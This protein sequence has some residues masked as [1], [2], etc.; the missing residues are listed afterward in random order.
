MS[1][2]NGPLILDEDSGED[3]LLSVTATLL[4]S[5]SEG[6]E[7]LN[8]E[9]KGLVSIFPP[10]G[11]LN[12]QL[13]GPAHPQDF[14]ATLSTL[15][16]ENLNDNHQNLHR[17]IEVVATDD[18]QLTS[19][20]S[21][22]SITILP[23]NDPPSLRL[24]STTNY[25]VVYT[26][27]SGPVQLTSAGF[28][29]SDV[30]SL[31]LEQAEIEILNPVDT[32][33]EFLI[34][35]STLLTTAL[36]TSTI[37]IVTGPAAVE[38]FASHL[39]SVRYLN[40]ATSPT[41][42][43]RVVRFLV[44]DGSL[45]DEAFTEVTVVPVNDP[46]VL[47]L[48]G[49]GQGVDSRV[50]FLEEGPPVS[51]TQ[52]SSL[53]IYDSDSS[54]IHS[55]TIQIVPP[56]NMRSEILTAN[57]STTV[58]ISSVFDTADATL[59]LSGI[60]S[61]EEY[62]STLLS[63]RY[64]NQADEPLGTQRT[65]QLHV[66][67]GELN[68]NTALVT[69]VFV[70]I[71]DAPVIT[72]DGASATYSTVFLENGPSVPLV[73]TR[74]AAITDVD[75]T[76]LAFLTITVYN[77]LNGNQEFLLFDNVS[78]LVFD[79]RI[80]PQK[81]TYN[82]TFAPS[83]AS[84][85]TYS[86]FLLSLSYINQ[87]KEPNATLSR[88][89]AVQTSD[90]SL[91]SNTAIS[92]IS[93]ILIDDNQPQFS[94]ELYHFQ[95]SEDS[96]PGVT[97]GS[98][99]ASDQD[100]GD[101]FFYAISTSSSSEV[102][103]FEINQSTGTL[104]LS[105]S[106]DREDTSSYNLT[107]LLTR[108]V[109]PFSVFDSTASVTITVLDVND[110]EPTFNQSAYE[111]VVSEN[112]SV[113][114]TVGH[115]V[116]DDRDIGLNGEVE[117]SLS[118]NVDD[119]TVNA[120]TGEIII[121]NLLDREI[122]SFFSFLVTARD[123]GT[124]SLSSQ[125]SVSVRVTDV[126]DN[127]P[128]FSQ[129]S[130]S[131]QL[132]ETTPVGTTILEIAASDEDSG[133]NAL[134]VFSL[135][136]SNSPFIL[137]PSTGVL[138]VGDTLSP[139]THQ[140]TLTA[141]DSGRP[142][143]STTAQLTVQVVSFN[144]T[145]PFF[146]QP[147]YEGTIVENSPPGLSILTVL[148]LDPVSSNP[149]IYSI[150]TVSDDFVIDANT[151]TVSSNTNFDRET[152]ALYQ[153]Q[154]TATAAADA[155]RQ[156]FA[157]VVIQVT[158][159]NDFPPM[160]T[161]TDYSFT[162]V[163]NLSP[164]ETVGAVLARD[165]SD[166]GDNAQITS[167]DISDPKFTVSTLGIIMLVG[168]LDR[169]L[170]NMYVMTI[171]AVDGGIPAL[172]GI[173]Q[174]TLEVLDENDNAP[175]FTSLTYSVNVTE[176][177]GVARFLLQVSAN[178]PDVGTNADIIYSTNS[179]SLVSIDSLSGVIVTATTYDFEENPVIN[180]TLFA[181][182]SGS[183]P[184]TAT[185]MLVINV[186]DIDDSPPIFSSRQYVA[187][188][189]EGQ[190]VNSHVVSLSAS[191]SDSSPENV[192]RFEILSGDT[193]AMFIVDAN[194]TLL[195]SAELD[196]ETVSQYSL[197]VEASNLNV[198]GDRI[199]SR[200]SVSVS[201][202]DVNDNP[203]QFLELPYLFS[204][205]ENSPGGQ[206]VGTV[207]VT[208]IDQGVNANITLFRI[209]SGDPGGDFSMDPLRGTLH[210]AEEGVIDRETLDTY[211]LV[212]EV[213]DGGT[214]QLSS[215]AIVTIE[216]TDIN[217][218]SP[219]FEEDMYTVVIAEDTPL[220][221][222]LLTVS[223]SD[224]D[225]GSNADV[226]YTINDIT[227]PV[228][229]NATSGDVILITPLDFES[230]S[231][232]DVIVIAVDGGIP[233]LSSST[234][235]SVVI[236]D[237]DDLPVVF[238]P[239][240]Y[241]V[242]VFENVPVGTTIATV[243]A[244]DLDTQPNTP[245]VYSLTV[246][247]AP[248]SIDTQSG[249][250][251][252][253]LPLDRESVASYVIT[254]LASNTPVVTASATVVIQIMD[255]HD[256][257]PSFPDGPFQFQ[258][259]ESAPV[260]M[261]LGQIV[262]V[263]GDLDLAGAIVEYTLINA[264]EFHI[265][266]STGV[267]SVA[268]ILDFETTSTYEIVVTARD[269]G[270][271]SLIGSSMVVIQVTDVNDNAPVFT[272]PLTT[273]VPE[274]EPVG[275]VIATVTATDVDSDDADIRFS[276]SSPIVPFS[277]DPLSGE[278]NI[279]APL[280]LGTYAVPIIATDSGG[281]PQLS[282]AT[283]TVMVTDSNEHPSFSQSSYSVELSEATSIGEQVVQVRATDSDVGPN[284]NL[285][286]S[287]QPSD[288][289]IIHPITGVITLSSTLDYEL[290]ESYTLVL[291]V[292]DSGSPPL[293]AR[294]ELIVRVLD[295]NDNPPLFS[296]D[297]YSV[298][299]AEDIPPNTVIIT[300][301]ASDLDSGNNG[302]I[303]YSI[304]QAS[305]DS[306][307]TIDP[308]SGEI[309][310]LR[311]L[312]F[313]TLDNF[314]LVI[315]VRDG[316]Q[317][318]MFSMVS[319]Y[320]TVDDVDD[321]PPIFSRNAYNV[322]VDEDVSIGLV[323][324]TLT[325]TDADSG[326][327]AHII[328][329]IINVTTAPFHVDSESGNVSIGFPGLDYEN[330]T[331]YHLTV[332][333]FN[334]FSS[335]FTATVTLII[336]VDDVN[337]NAPQFEPNSLIITVPESSP[338]GTVLGQV[339]AT[340]SD[341]GTNS[342]LEYG[343]E[344]NTLLAVDSDTGD[345][346]LQ[347]VLDFET[348]SVV[349]I[350]V[351]VHDA[352][353]PR[354]VMNSTLVLNILD[355]NDNAPVLSIDPSGF[356]FT[357]GSDSI[358]IGMGIAV[359]DSDTLP[360]QS[361]SISLYL[362]SI[363]SETSSSDFIT[364][365]RAFSES[366]GL[367]VN[368]T[369]H[370]IRLQ[371]SQ[372]AGIYVSV[373]RLLRFGNT[374]E[375]P[376]ATGRLIEISVR[377]S[378]FT[379]NSAIIAVTV[380]LVN[381]N[382]PVLDL[383][384][385][386]VDGLDYQ[387]VFIE[388]GFFV[389]AVSSDAT[390]TDPDG[391]DFEYIRAII[392]NPLDGSHEQISAFSTSRDV[393]VFQN[394]SGLYLLGPA[395]ASSFESTLRSITYQNAAD[396]P[397]EPQTER[398]IRFEVSDGQFLSSPVTT[399]VIIQPVNDPPSISLGSST[400]D[401]I[402]TYVESVGYVEVFSAM[403]SLRDDDSTKLSFVN[404]T[405]RDYQSSVDRFNFTIAN[406]G[407]IT[408]QFLS[409]TLLV[410]G[411]ANIDEF[412]DVLRSVRY[413]NSRVEMD[414]FDQLGVSRIIEITASDGGSATS[415]IA[416]AFVTFQAVNDP[417]LV[418]LNGPDN[419][420]QDIDI[421][422]VEGDERVRVASEQATVV[423]VDSDTLSFVA[424]QLFGVADNESETLII[425]E[426]ITNIVSSYNSFTNTLTLSGPA[427]VAEF[428]SVLR[429]LHYVNI[430]SEP[431]PG[432]R[433]IEIV[434]SDAMATSMAAIA[435][436]SIAAIN[437][438]PT[439]S[440]MGSGRP[441]MEGGD[442]VS[443]FLE[444]TV[445]LR[446]SDNSVLSS[447]E[448][449]IE[450]ALDGP[451]EVISSSMTEDIHVMRTQLSPSLT[452]IFTF[453]ATSEGT[454]EDFT[455]LVE[456]L[457]YLNSAAEPSPQPR[458]ISFR[459]S[460]SVDYSDAINITVDIILI[461]DNHPMFTNDNITLSIPE[462]ASIGEIIASLE[463]VD[464]DQDS[465]LEYSLLESFNALFT[466]TPSSGVVM[467]NGALDRETSDRYSL[468]IVVS[469]ELNTASI[470]VTI[471]ITDVND[472]VP[473]FSE[474][475]V[476]VSISES[477]NIG[478]PVLLI[479]ATDDDLGENGRL[480]FSISNNNEESA[481][482]IDQ[483]SGLL[484]TSVILD[485]E[486]VETYSLLVMVSDRGIPPLSSSTTV[487]VAVTDVNDNSP[488]FIPDS[489]SV[490]WS[491][492]IGIG[493]ELYT[494]RAVDPDSS[495]HLLYTILSGNNGTLFSVDPIFG[496]IILEI[497][498][499]RENDDKHVLIIEA[500]D[501]VFAA[502]LELIIIVLDVDD[503]PPTFTRNFQSISL[504][505]NSTVGTVLL[506][507]NASD[508]DT[509]LNAAFEYRI[510]SGD[511]TSRFTINTNT[512]E[513][514]LAGAVDRE[515]EDSYEL[516]I[517]VRSLS[518][519][520]LNDTAIVR[521]LLVDIND[522]P[523]IFEM[524]FYEFAALENVTNGTVIGWV[525]ASDEDLGRNGEVSFSL[526]PISTIFAINTEGDIIVTSGLDHEE[527]DEYMLSVVAQDN[528]YPSL[529]ATA[530]VVVSVGDIN[531]NTPLFMGDMLS[532]TIQ[533]N[534][535]VGSEITTVTATDADSGENGEIMY[536]I[537][538]SDN[539]NL[540]A[541]NRDNGM[542]VTAVELDFERHPS[543]LHITVTAYDSGPQS[544]SSSIE[545]E[546]ILLEINEF[547]PM[548][549][550]TEY[551]VQ[552]S[553]DLPPSTVILTVNAT[554][555]DIGNS[556][557]IEYGLSGMT[558]SME[559]FIINST[560]GDITTL[561][562]LDR[563]M[564]SFHEII[565][566]ATNTHTNPMLSSQ[567]VVVV[568]L[569]DVNDN[570]PVFDQSEYSIAVVMSTAVGTTLLSVG[571]TDADS[572]TNS[573]ILYTGTDTSGYFQVSPST[574]DIILK[575]SFN[576][577]STITFTVT[578]S[579]LGTPT[580]SASVTVI[581]RVIQPLGV[582][583]S[584]HG[585]GFLLEETASV[586]QSFGLFANVPPG[587]EGMLTASLG[588][589][590]IT[591]AYVTAHP[592][593]VGVRGVVLDERVWHDRPEVG[594]VVQVYGE[595]G[596]VHCQPTEV[597]VTINPDPAIGS[598]QT[599]QVTCTSS[600]SDGFCEAFVVLPEA[601]FDHDL[602]EA[603][604]SVTIRLLDSDDLPVII[605]TV[606]I[607]AEPNDEV[608][609]GIVL[610][611]PSRPQSPGELFTAV[612]AAHAGYPV[613]TFSLRCA[614]SAQLSIEE[615]VVDSVKWT[616][617]SRWFE[618]S[619]VGIAAF[620]ADPVSSESIED[621]ITDWEELFSLRVRVKQDVSSSGII[622][623]TL[624]Y[625]SNILNDKL[626]PRGLV[627]PAPV[628]P[629]SANN[630]RDSPH[631]VILVASSVP[632]ALLSYASQA[633]IVNTAVFNGD[634][635]Q[636]GLT[637]Y[638]VY[639]NGLASISG[640]MVSCDSTSSAFQLSTDCSSVLLT[641]NETSGADMDEIHVSFGNFTKTISLRV[642]YPSTTPSIIATPSTAQAVS[643]W[644]ATDTSG[645]CTQ[646]YLPI[647]LTVHAIYSYHPTLGPSFTVNVL[648]L[649]QDVLSSSDPTV[650]TVLNS[651]TVRA[652]S[653]G[654]SVISAGESI[655]PATVTVTNELLQ[656]SIIETT[657][658]T[659]LQLSLPLPRSYGIVS[660]QLA[661]T[662]IEQ[663][664]SSINT[665][666]YSSVSA[667]ASDGS[668]FILT[669]E[670]GLQFYSL[671]HSIVQISDNNSIS[672]VDS[673][674]GDFL[675]V[676]WVSP[677][678]GELIASDVVSLEVDIPDPVD[679]LI[680]LSSSRI[681]RPG[682][683]AE[684]SGLPTSS[685]LSIT[686]IYT[687]GLTQDVT[688]HPDTSIKFIY[689]QDLVNI[690]VLTAPSLEHIISTMTSVEFGMVL[691]T[692]SYKSLPAA[693]VN[694]SLG[695]VGFERLSLH[696]LPYPTYPG[697]E[698]NTKSV[699]YQ[700]EDTGVFQ[701]ASLE[702]E[703]V[704]SDNSTFSVTESPLTIF[705]ITNSSP[706]VS[707][708]DNIVLSSG[709][710]MVHIEGRFGT[711]SAATTLTFSAQPVTITSLFNFTLIETT[712]SD[713]LS[714]EIGY[715]SSLS[716]DAVFNDSTVFTSF[717][718][719]ADG[720]FQSLISITSDTPT[721]ARVSSPRGA[722]TLT[723]N[724][725]S[726]ITLTAAYVTSGESV[727]LN[728]FCNLQP[729]VGDVDVGFVSGPPIPPVKIDE[730]FTVPVT[731]NAGTQQMESF[732]LIMLY[733][734]GRLSIV[735]FANGDDWQLGNL[736]VDDM[737]SQGLIHVQGSIDN[738]ELAPSGLVHVA[739]LIFMADGVGTT[740]LDGLV[741]SLVDIDGV[742]IPTNG[743]ANRGFVAGK[744]S[745]VVSAELGR[746]RRAIRPEEVRLRFRRNALCLTT[747]P[748]VV[749]ENHRERGD[750]N[751][752]C[753]F[754][755][756]DPTYLLAYHT[757]HLFDFQLSS[758]S[759]LLLSL[760]PAQLEALDVDGNTV[761][762]VSDAY[763]LSQ[764]ETGHLKFLTDI[765]IT[766]VQND[767]KCFFA[768]N[769][770]LAGKGDS[771]ATDDTTV[772][773][774]DISLPFDPSFENQRLFEES[775]FA[776][777]SLSE[778]SKGVSLQGGILEAEYLAPGTFGVQFQ[779]NVTSDDIGLGVIQI[780]SSSG[781]M[782]SL[783]RTRALLGHP[784]PP[785]SYPHA[786]NLN[787]PAFSDSTTIS[788]L[789]GYNPLTTF[790]NTLSSGVC[791]TPPGPPIVSPLSY[792]VAITENLPR[793]TTVVEIN[794]TSQSNEPLSFSIITGNVDDVF[795]IDSFGVVIVSGELD[796]EE[797][798]EFELE[799]AVTDPATSRYTTATVFITV[800][801][802]NDNAPQFTAIP[803]ILLPQNTPPG[804]VIAT[805]TASDADSGTSADITF[806]I[807]SDDNTF[808]IEETLGVI[809]LMKSLDFDTQSYYEVIITAFDGG[810]PQLNSTLSLNVTVLPPDPTV[811]EFSTPLLNHS[812]A[813][814][815]PPGHVIIQ[816]NAVP[817]SNETLNVTINYSLNAPLNGLFTID[818]MTGEVSVSGSLDR[819]TQDFY[820]LQVSASITNI[821]RSVP[822]FA[823]VSITVLDINDNPP[824]FVQSNYST[825]LTE[826]SP[827]GSLH[828]A[829]TA[830]D[831]D[832]RENGTIVFTL[833]ED[834]PLLYLSNGILSNAMAI[835]FENH[836]VLDVSVIASDQG[837]PPLSTAINVTIMIED[838]NDNPPTITAS[839]DD[840]VT[841]SEGLLLGTT[842]FTVS[843]NDR[844]S[845]AVNG[846]VTLSLVN[847][848]TQFIF[849]TTTGDIA[850]VQSLDYESEQNLTILVWVTDSGPPVMSS[851]AELVV[852]IEDENDNSPIFSENEYSIVVSEFESV[853]SV[854][855]SLTITD[856]D[857]EPYTA[858]E[859]TFEPGSALTPFNLTSDG[860][861]I[862]SEPLDHEMN[863]AY[864]LLVRAMNTAPGAN[865]T[866]TNISVEVTDENEFFP[867]FDMDLYNA[868]VSEE[869]AGEFVITI[870]ATDMDS[871]ANISYMIRGVESAI[872]DISQN[873][874]ILTSVPLDRENV[875]NYQVIVVASD[876]SQSEKISTAIIMVTVSDI[877]DNAPTILPFDD[878]SIS[879]SLVPG[880][881]VAT[882]R[883]ED[884]DEGENGA[885]Q[886]SLREDATDFNISVT[887]DLLVAAALNALDTPQHILTLVA[888][889]QGSPSLSSSALVTITILTFP[890]PYFAE[891]IYTANITENNSK[892]VS[893]LQV[894][895]TSRD[896]N[897][898]ITYS[899]LPSNDAIIA[900][901]FS[902]DSNT[903]VVKILESLD[904]EET[905]F[906]NFT[907]VASVFDNGSELTDTAHI[908]VYVEDMNDN[909]PMFDDSDFTVRVNETTLNGSLVATFHASDNDLDQNA[910]IYYSLTSLNSSES[911][912]FDIDRT[913]GR[914]TTVGS[915]V[916]KTGNYP[917]LLQA[918]NPD[919]VGSLS[920]TAAVTVIVDHINEFPPVFGESPY[921][922][923]IREDTVTGINP[924]LTVS[925]T[926][927]DQGTAGQVDYS[928]IDNPALSLFSLNSTTGDITLSSSLDYETASMFSLLVSAIDSGVPSR[929]AVSEILVM[930]LDVNDN[931]PVFSQP[932]YSGVIE[933]NVAR[934]QS[935]LQLVVSDNDTEINSQ[936]NYVIITPLVDM[937]FSVY[938]NGMV[939][940]EVEFDADNTTFSDS[941]TFDVVAVNDGAGGRLSAAAT[942]MVYV[943]DLNDNS[944]LFSELV[945]SRVIKS[946]QEAGI[947]VITV[948]ARDE[949]RNEENNQIQFSLTN[950]VPNGILEI[951]PL[952]GIVSLAQSVEE[953]VNISAVVV[954]RDSGNPPN[955]VTTE[956]HVTVLAPD[957]LTA[958]REYDITLSSGPGLSLTGF[959]TET[960]ENT[961]QQHISFALGR[962]DSDSHTF[963]A[964]LGREMGSIQIPLERLAP[965]SV[966]AVLMTPD[967]WHDDRRIQVALQVR[968][969]FG[970]VQ[971]DATAHPMVQVTHPSITPP[972]GTTC[973]PSLR[974]GICIVTID[975][976]D[977]WFIFDAT[978]LTVSYGLTV[979]AVL[980]VLGTVQLYPIPHFNVESSIYVYLEMP[981]R[982]LIRGEEITVPVYGEAGQSSVTSY[983][984]SID[985]S[986]EVE[987]NELIV[988]QSDWQ[989]ETIPTVTGGMTIT[990]VRA[991]QTILH[992]SGRTHLFDISATISPN[993]TVLDTLVDNTITISILF[994]GDSD[995]SQLLPEPSQPSVPALALT[996][997]GIEAVG[998]L[999][1000]DSDKPLGL[1001]A[1002][1003]AQAE[1004]VNT[1005]LL[1006][1007]NTVSVPLTT[1008]SIQRHAPI[1009][1010][1011][1012]PDS[1013][1014]SEDENV[1015][1016]TDC[1017]M[1018]YISS[1019]QTQGSESAIVTVSFSDLRTSFPVRVWV[1020][1021]F[1022][1023]KLTS[1024]DTVLN[1025]VEGWF[1026]SSM[1027]CRPNYQRTTIRAFSN[1028]TNSNSS[1029]W[1030]IDVTDVVIASLHSTNS[1031]IIEVN[1032]DIITGISPGV[1033]TIQ[1034]QL[1035][1036]KT[1037]EL[1038]FNVTDIPS[1039]VLGLDVRVITDLRLLATP[1040]EGNRLTGT[1041]LN[1042]I[1043][1044]QNFASEGA[1045]GSVITA[1046]VFDDGSRMILNGSYDGISLLSLNTSVLRLL[1047]DGETV[1048]ALGS[1049]S[1050]DL[1051]QAEWR[1052]N[1053][1054]CS[1055]ELI[1056]SGVEEL[1057]IEISPVEGSGAVQHAHSRRR[1058]HTSMQPASELNRPHWKSELSQPLVNDDISSMEVRDLTKSYQ[1059]LPVEKV[1060]RA[1061][1062]SH[1063]RRQIESVIGD[1064]DGNGIFNE[1065]DASFLQRYILTLTPGALVSEET[1066]QQGQYLDIDLSGGDPN[1067]NDVIFL[1068]KMTAGL[1069]QF[1070]TDLN[1071]SPVTDGNCDF[1072]I[1073]V[1074]LTDR[1075]N[1076]P[1077]MPDSASVFFHFVHDNPTFQAMFDSTN[1078]TA[1079]GRVPLVMAD[1080][1081]H[1082]G[1083]VRAEYTSEGVFGMTSSSAINIT[1084]IGVSLIL[1085]TYDN[1086]SETSAL[1087]TVGLFQSAPPVFHSLNLDFISGGNQVSIRR[1088]NGYA[1089]LRYVDNTL[1090]TSECR[1091]RQ[1092]SLFFKQSFYVG[1093]VSENAS[1094]IDI[1095][1096][1097]V[1098]AVTH[1099]PG[1100]IVTYSISDP[1101]RF[1102]F[1103]VNPQTGEIFVVGP[1104]DFDE[1105][1106][1107]DY[1108]FIVF[1109][1110]EIT[1111]AST[1112]MHAN[1113]TV[1114]VDVININD[1115]APVIN[1116]IP[1117]FNL[1118]A[1119]RTVGD[1120]IFTVSASDPDK[1121]TNQLIYGLIPESS[1122]DFM[1123][1124]S[1125]SGAVT[1126]TRS[1127][1128]DIANSIALLNISVSDGLLT[1129]HIQVEITI[1130]LPSF[1131]SQ[1132][1133]TVVIPEDTRIG[1134]TVLHVVIN[1135][1136]MD[1137]QFSFS[1138]SNTSLFSIL[1139]GLNNTSATI[1140]VNG[1141]LDYEEMTVH[1142]I[1143]ILADSS[1144]FHLEAGVIIT[1145]TDVNDNCPMFP[1146]TQYTISLTSQT[1147]RGTVITD[1148]PRAE[1149]ADSEENAVVVYDITSQPRPEYF[1150]IN[1151][1152]SGELTL[1153][1154]SLITGPSSLLIN[1155]T[1156]FDNCTSQVNGS[1157]S[1158]LFEITL[1159]LPL[1160]DSTRLNV[1161]FPSP[1162]QAVLEWNLL[1163]MGTG[1164]D[1165]RTLTRV[1166]IM[1167][1168][1169][1170]S[1171]MG[1172]AS[1173]DSGCNETVES[1174]TTGFTNHTT[1175]TQPFH[1176]YTFQVL[1177][1178]TTQSLRSIVRSPEDGMCIYIMP[1179]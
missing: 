700:F 400:R 662:G 718:P 750:I 181:T 1009:S 395:E 369:P 278:I 888:N 262:A 311:G 316:G 661:T 438:P 657:V 586:S 385:S 1150:S 626:Q 425:N 660:S 679:I 764:V 190:P 825:T 749:C 1096:L 472:N 1136:A 233:Q 1076:N 505:E 314:E 34:A 674:T 58:S 986:P 722:V 847:S 1172:V 554:D 435:T 468:F 408:G 1101:N 902:I 201:V 499:D 527:E 658:F 912:L 675:Q 228:T 1031:S 266:A 268:E 697:S 992:A 595:V 111:F 343:I 29:L 396:E 914:L 682:D 787:L 1170:I 1058:R 125:A 286:F 650:V 188:V 249:D 113:G 280:M 189:R 173:S 1115:L 678:T 1114:H 1138:I 91:A 478:T 325:A 1152:S 23:T 933:E 183:V 1129:S 430:A 2:T 1012:T 358:P 1159:I 793:G 1165:F 1015:V 269:G 1069:Y 924:L 667:V 381:D 731:V 557:I 734:S 1075:T 597:A 932:Q 303:T 797:I 295:D 599:P 1168:C 123:R 298:S 975:L 220:N 995:L 629:I 883:A 372:S 317:P 950:I 397:S 143:L 271:P 864:N 921:N 227:L 258:V 366:Q 1169:G 270:A 842:L 905:G 528:G 200:T 1062:K 917:F 275:V 1160:I 729:T 194:G 242:S 337:D 1061:I 28:Q 868:S 800:S 1108:E 957:D 1131:S 193:N 403:S 521:I 994:L 911:E 850:L 571:A 875:S 880:T 715:E 305:T 352:G 615:L 739:N 664:F 1049:G 461:N 1026:D 512:G 744:I 805:I 27:G 705:L 841:V 340:D 927:D 330:V 970:N 76:N 356:T 36:S 1104:L 1151:S 656:I 836:E 39:Q 500:S 600:I 1072:S 116:A 151:G 816:L 141:T 536:R 937:L 724:H 1102:P 947:T 371:G 244:R 453:L 558:R 86:D 692:V 204:V 762:D 1132:N 284:A 1064:I 273:S 222:V 145:L 1073:N 152:Q 94:P 1167:E 16:Y 497:S 165:S 1014:S 447:V 326:V 913:N 802:I 320:I 205:E 161:Q 312:D 896:P 551:A 1090:T 738:A 506:Q 339:I 926:D 136:P 1068:L 363:G 291:T 898:S 1112:V 735:E 753:I 690:S 422:F 9:G 40:N 449:V 315:Q 530:S 854:L 1080:G 555:M 1035:G 11:G 15:R 539:A 688:T 19:E 85:A 982:P 179:P 33:T 1042:I 684:L 934:G 73:N 997:R 12:L 822:A 195:T 38:L 519:P 164:G 918:S 202:L 154:V 473:I 483:D 221:S 755:D 197:I 652:L 872:F 1043:T 424:A 259:L 1110:E 1121:L 20:P 949:D 649:I 707:I 1083:L 104:S 546:I 133:S 922:L 680:T 144:S 493:S 732:Q 811:L 336:S 342:V 962:Q 860:R 1010:G 459:I 177:V 1089:P 616:Y 1179:N 833:L 878:L 139:L 621:A 540:F 360:L 218:N 574:G 79:R 852:Y 1030:N 454:I 1044:E 368:A 1105:L 671:D 187:T 952:T 641:G 766:P 573:E 457:S 402:L 899:L 1118:P 1176:E 673:G 794:A 935:I 1027:E 543:T 250:I 1002:Y 6:G 362:G 1164:L 267:V 169:E 82:F 1100:S 1143:T 837:S 219:M 771:L 587:S 471:H 993:I 347:D 1005:A 838:M 1120:I 421:Q 494:A 434:A 698:Q 501:G 1006:T 1173:Q 1177:G 274:N 612:A 65:L 677:C 727:E 383:S 1082:G 485:R 119:F 583:F 1137:E 522:S 301:S 559:L 492:D 703:A 156:S 41:F 974:D 791:L 10:S 882:F 632:R 961:Y 929:S 299:L 51:I 549:E 382:I 643:G 174:V 398:F 1154:R 845:D 544:L 848:S 752:D 1000:I 1175:A 302:A 423:D 807:E 1028:F 928:L 620:L 414:Q 570:S 1065:D 686:V 751:G 44:H 813:E 743:V 359:S 48:N 628:R 353:N 309:A 663:E 300:V 1048:V 1127:L 148:A 834:L 1077:A 247:E 24:S 490:E 306:F 518:N 778:S 265:N 78:G 114:V 1041:T 874:S 1103:A 971:T 52:G 644:I 456:S 584:Q 861:L 920:T 607:K 507:H 786:L 297:N 720:V 737:P 824:E 310:T 217:D 897:V 50:Q 1039:E 110:N 146:S 140:L 410:T 331:E 1166:Y 585:A 159:A 13:A 526:L 357:E 723:G 856:A 213:I 653:A 1145:I 335:Q 101:T 862:L 598:S 288:I 14:E 1135:G 318:F 1059:L 666:V 508:R 319:V 63:V 248:F 495:S 503:N 95:L 186:R 768:I 384:G 907:V 243:T 930:V 61:I 1063:F 444:N 88:L 627:T 569:L 390:L 733:N 538:S 1147:P 1078:I 592:R 256:V 153:L 427:E 1066:P 630:E 728:L 740:S 105:Q 717:I 67:D 229:V 938:E 184:L 1050:A 304:V 345:I 989:V 1037:S 364:L 960:S 863:S 308:T 877:N 1053:A 238:E 1125:T 561:S 75:S 377:D 109:S 57:I 789:N 545:I 736:E 748:C 1045:Q 1070:I 234:S 1146:E 556:G 241:S 31:N 90:G 386:S 182:D 721:A 349:E 53:T 460:D 889:D 683:R 582:E 719:Q 562:T 843:V 212:I 236:T 446:D 191:D 445:S 795:S 70:F 216:V 405:V 211:E 955:E 42:G 946:P 292:M 760:I 393:M 809:M 409:G 1033:A 203:P 155:T 712:N 963:T 134:L 1088:Q 251:S 1178:P 969:N 464:N 239:D 130:Y 978:N 246:T 215:T 1134:V 121:E 919:S 329:D 560:S 916:D 645:Q 150:D 49:D 823:V 810:E 171:T 747:P 18:G 491:E 407:N 1018:L 840:N 1144:N 1087:R 22:I 890:A 942:V 633:Q 533:E 1007:G 1139:T 324:L 232:Y 1057:E 1156:A 120:L 953:A 89:A 481:F 693:T 279:T 378:D 361:A 790:S 313:E 1029:V 128:Q 450:N 198:F 510:V 891:D 56:L 1047:E 567:A 541:I 638:V 185:A 640:H 1001:F 441:Y 475:E 711:T 976:P 418:D 208:D 391:D 547:P 990:A 991:D 45:A 225:L 966:D 694:V 572:G 972:L 254:A 129:S 245:I 1171:Q 1109:A 613:A 708:S 66:N 985:T 412:R 885:I 223:A 192:I 781:N 631:G 72:L 62:R 725:H 1126:P 655:T 102:A 566:Q 716:L 853:G 293:S 516:V 777:G 685:N 866:F 714:G 904:R 772:V 463:A 798:S 1162:Y 944:P 287:I 622:N 404:I 261:E 709:A 1122:T 894:Q 1055:T 344:T 563:E 4:L 601:W 439:L 480:S 60:A 783:A 1157:T 1158:V 745:L 46:P 815:V 511:A 820:E 1023:I 639:S 1003:T 873:G 730:T 1099:R 168:E 529:L 107:I 785:F 77:I 531:D 956:L 654:T 741:I 814:N 283:L 176:E 74:S 415:Q 830:S 634:L 118:G 338:V 523:P 695:V 323:I 322:T 983:T 142:P 1038:E 1074:T 765:S 126:N 910:V 548:F 576:D 1149:D 237:T 281:P 865:A 1133:Y 608:R 1:V 117:Y 602:I 606:E 575:Q 1046:A 610:F 285:T 436:I 895:A 432:L 981:F 380:D 157:Q 903:G 147:S 25:S 484:S 498:L 160:F 623:C 224:T 406:G 411:P 328:Y 474:T 417:P 163:E 609:N 1060:D 710:T 1054:T 462:S 84:V 1174:G 579:D 855:L 376:S 71:N 96:M 1085:V 1098:C 172:T 98:V 452:Y 906:Y 1052:S 392:D 440:A 799:I 59:T 968:D 964:H 1086:M 780:T 951:D 756:S 68:S 289:F 255:V 97:F 770:T 431:V 726:S 517:T 578:A 553:E 437:D 1071:I 92:T 370:S 21:F 954:A 804:S 416:S 124:P 1095:V 624:V 876:N 206:V 264:S 482:A 488:V 509:G 1153:E 835:D 394:S 581:I 1025:R 37:L 1163:N 131:V 940:S 196:R 617:E 253:S 1056:A 625:L 672:L 826:N 761:S 637:H 796:Y 226:T 240:T 636:V 1117:L 757:E 1093:S 166:I 106:L 987:L 413:I 1013:C 487:T 277:I 1021:E 32:D 231:Q 80:E 773:Y 162:A 55:V 908:E 915:L 135:L 100:E 93:V 699:F 948:S 1034:C 365:D 959:P 477:V 591:S 967:V 355:V 64:Q 455:A 681:T 767:S 886:F 604:A 893:L 399:S 1022:P 334:P 207:L 296:Q 263:D 577:T 758:G 945:Y 294:A 515:V 1020:P 122:E 350:T 614:V 849:N 808:D 426:T 881:L 504:P 433:T 272:S 230:Q 803:P 980:D 831:P 892:N 998:S 984:L 348:G 17:I 670:D 138:S 1024:L 619:E 958:G 535:P 388:D 884:L 321:N 486:S 282:T 775:L 1079:G 1119:N 1161:T 746:R 178:D 479:N 7:I 180:V 742:A 900:T 469:D 648:P 532:I 887:G 819:E 687:G 642:W 696:S 1107:Q 346:V 537:D 1155:L 1128:L 443:L 635:L 763:Y 214:P 276:I 199:G 132:V 691:L 451:S 210:V 596:E 26:E 1140:A 327:N 839:P 858:T 1008:L 1092:L 759:S 593:A 470:L 901:L 689:G 534:S 1106:A 618:T 112:T 870:T 167:Y 769:A 5:D 1097:Q 420:G 1084:G 659:D 669:S 429:S 354:L 676:N 879:E 909:P 939:R 817:V 931:P 590:S 465:I 859:F 524:S 936:I 332:E 137:Q 1016:Q 1148:Y 792:R 375:E 1011:I 565:I 387:T 127:Q 844:D 818:A 977:E 290:V 776:F 568:D 812:L 871:T 3:I 782:T 788:Y 605:G 996:R 550:Q 476:E 1091:L 552:V 158:D 857:S 846:Q 442:P 83:L 341:S 8:A 580:M 827:P 965:T 588:D 706:L 374:A 869:T 973:V 389:F 943:E 923:T 611:L 1142:K 1017:S 260:G 467:L 647:S 502:A 702:L 209:V 806:T 1081:Q 1130:F 175:V 69:V 525:M 1124:N 651:G 30:D 307:F 821:R 774:F 1036:S 367:S 564:E 401:A 99:F 496:E 1040:P 1051:I 514:I 87:A 594:V 1116:S 828:L 35:D 108:T 829:I 170:Q 1032:E 1111:V 448:V 466:I 713:T 832:L 779:S 784:D 979:G 351:T 704:L 589:V 103:P 603:I 1141:T 235:V 458:V 333:A 701:K 373:M 47:D 257:I 801:D 149:V 988:D 941:Y 925:A 489:V 668:S 419:I 115:P 754:D 252:V 1123:I 81:L 1067:P 1113:T 428:Q 999:Y 646:Q 1004:L 43:T 520:S 379:S 665:N 1094:I 851:T 513:L 1019:E 542:I 867:M 54:T